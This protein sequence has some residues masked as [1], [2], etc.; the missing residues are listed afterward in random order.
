MARRRRNRREDKGFN[1]WRSYSDMMAGVLLLFVLIMCVT[2][3]QAQKNYV[4]KIAEQE[5]RI[6]LQ[7][8][9]AAEMMK[10][11]EELAEQDAL[12]A[13]QREK[14]EE[15]NLTLDEMQAALEAQA[16]TLSEK[17][18]TLEE[19]ESV[20]A[21]QRAT[22]EEQKA[23]LEEQ[24]STLQSQQTTMEEQRAALDAQQATL[25]AQQ[26]T[27]EEQKTLLSSQAEEIANKTQQLKDKQAQ[28]DRIVGVK[29]EVIEA[30]Q[31]EFT[32]NNV[33]VK[34]DA[35]TGALQL[36]ANVMFDYDSAQLSEEGMEVLR[37]VLPI[38]CRV[39]LS[40]Q[41]KENVAEIIIDG[42]T[43]TDG[44]YDYNLEL[45]QMRSLAVAQFLLATEG[46][47]LNENDSQT[48]RDI[49]TVNGHSWSNPILDAEGNIDMDASRRVEVKF[50]LK[51]E[52]MI[53]E[54]RNLME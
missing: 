44:T 33:N 18:A 43:D 14:L 23:T 30:L 46:E 4:E 51:D 45:S 27:L 28:I 16:K 48:L 24:Q 39:L 13:E 7:D 50:R 2:L 36:D 31:K 1:V 37:Q 40:D 15:Q 8:E 29:A 38:Y 5:Q 47:F 54:L 32:A 41:Y 6:R 25:D 26:A 35:Q 19:Q 9:Y 34:I 3:F 53:E 20:L 49:L 17:Q 12:L 10:K 11:Q 52:E 42:Y 21:Q 22:M